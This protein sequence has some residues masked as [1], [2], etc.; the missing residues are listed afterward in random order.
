M[1]PSVEVLSAWK[2][3]IKTEPGPGVSASVGFRKGSWGACLSLVLAILFH[4]LLFW[5]VA[6]AR[7][8][9]SFAAISDIHAAHASYEN[10]L[11]EINTPTVAGE[12]RGGPADFLIVLGDLSPVSVNYG[13]F[14]RVFSHR[15]PLFLPAR[16]NHERKQDLQ[17]IDR[18]ILPAATAALGES[19][20]RFSRS[21]LSY[22]LD[23]KGSRVI[24]LDQYADFRKTAP[25]PLALRWLNKALESAQSV[26]H[27]FIGFHE[28]VFPWNAEDDPL[29][30]ILQRHRSVIRGI[31]FGHTHVYFRT[32]FPS[33]FEGI[34]VIN[35]GNAGQSTHS[36]GRQTIVCVIVDGGSARV[37][38]LQ[39]PDGKREFRVSDTFTLNKP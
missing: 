1:C 14:E 6:L 24:I 25:N 23:W 26:D 17:V 4:N 3:A 16:G 35:V 7:D 11:N 39:A 19:V 2:K 29:W 13:I 5:N 22:W 18:R 34:Q 12:D 9:W 33:P 30:S 27:V 36:D 37:L 21:G 32:R 20:N 28:P 15:R 10:V 38:T 31:L 8:R